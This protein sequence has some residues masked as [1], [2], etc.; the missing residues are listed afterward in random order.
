M[1]PRQAVVVA[2]VVAVAAAAGKR[3]ES[4]QLFATAQEQPGKQNA[5]RMDTFTRSSGSGAVGGG[6]ARFRDHLPSYIEEIYYVEP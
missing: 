3:S 4:P 5:S 6:T 1:L 2:A